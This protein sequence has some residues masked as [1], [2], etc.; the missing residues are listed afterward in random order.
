LSSL[1]TRWYWI[2]TRSFDEG[3]S[4]RPH[5]VIDYDGQAADEKARMAL[6]LLT[7]D[8]RESSFQPRRSFDR[9]CSGRV[10][11][12]VLTSTKVATVT[13]EMVLIDH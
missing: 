12:S 7:R 9:D 8:A 11:R 2:K 10:F 6:S 4:W 1:T 5:A 13:G 3:N